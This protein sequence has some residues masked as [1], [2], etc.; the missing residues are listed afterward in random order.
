MK[1]TF[2]TLDSGKCISPGETVIVI[3]RPQVKIHL[4][5]LYIEPFVADRFD[6]AEVRIGTHSKF[7]QCQSIPASQFSDGKGADFDIGECEILQN[8]AMYVTN[9][10]GSPTRFQATWACLVRDTKLSLKDRESEDSKLNNIQVN[11]KPE[12]VKR[13]NCPGFGWDPYDD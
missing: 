12:L 1:N 8:V 13:N 3:A 2:L 10:S 5:R 4:H 7:P 11:G 6:I 9:K